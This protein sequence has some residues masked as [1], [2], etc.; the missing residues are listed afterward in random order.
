MKHFCEEGR[1]PQNVPRV[2]ELTYPVSTLT[3]K[4]DTDIQQ[5]Q[6]EFFQIL[7][8]THMF[9]NLTCLDMPLSISFQFTLTRAITVAILDSTLL[10]CEPI[11][12][13]T[14]VGSFP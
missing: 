6:N 10:Y 1:T 8:P 4:T 13:F 2:T 9:T 3:V 5:I 11:A 7:S 14:I 12:H